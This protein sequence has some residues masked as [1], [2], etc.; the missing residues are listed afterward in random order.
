MYYLHWLDSMN[1][2]QL[3]PSH[4]SITV[5]YSLPSA[6]L[7]LF[8]LFCPCILMQPTFA[9]DWP[10]I[11]GLERNSIAQDEKLL[12]QWP[13]SGPEV[14]WKIKVGTGY[15]GPA[16][17]DDV[18]ILFHR[19]GDVERVEARKL[20]D[21]TLI[22]KQDFP[23]QYQPS[24]NPDDGPRCVPQILEERIVV[25]GVGGDLRVL[26]R[27]DGKQVWTKNVLEEYA[28]NSGYFGAG[29]SPLVVDEQVLVNVGGR[30]G[31]VVAFALSTGKE[32]WKVMDLG[33]SYSSPVLTTIAGE[34]L[35]IFVTRLELVSLKPDTG[36]V[37]HR[38]PFGQR[39][40][41]VNA[42]TPQVSGNELFLTASY[43]IGAKLINLSKEPPEFIWENDRSLSSQY[44][45]PVKRGDYLYGIH[46]REDV[47]G[48]ELRCIAW[49][50]GEVQWKETDFGVAHFIAVS[51]LLLVV[52][53]DGELMLVEATPE[54]FKPLST[55]SVTK[56]HLR[57]LPALS[58]GKLLLKISG[59]ENALIALQVGKTID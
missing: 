7:T 18:V 36:T 57:S 46:G 45:T 40:P 54:K 38:F 35:A 3:T 49:K 43:G 29:S 24:I 39:G 30:E 2:S 42:A 4:E 10:Q 34:K 50:S 14:A 28:G 58:D 25:Y 9:G 21:G 51:E 37:I 1:D 31:G 32:M 44:S 15:A 53:I 48:A 17:R 47:P 11:L 23:V 12:P 33:A 5:N 16:V 27:K 59:A 41:T 22:W 52:K 20:A 13:K 55:Y 6:C 26:S 19:V 56:D 8:H